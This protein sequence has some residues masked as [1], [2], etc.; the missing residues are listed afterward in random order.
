MQFLGDALAGL[1]QYGK[2]TAL[3]EFVV[4]ELTGKKFE[5]QERLLFKWLK[6]V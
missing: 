6:E 2:R 3:C 1:I 5:E 4:K